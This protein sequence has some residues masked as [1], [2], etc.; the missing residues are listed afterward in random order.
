[1]TPPR[2]AGARG[3]GA[4]PRWKDRYFR[5]ASLRASLTRFAGLRV[6]VGT[7]R[8]GAG[9][10]QGGRR[11]YVVVGYG[12]VSAQV[13]VQ[14]PGFVLPPHTDGPDH[15]HAVSIVL[16]KPD[17]GELRFFGPHQ[18]LARGRVAAFD[19]GQVDHYVTKIEGR[20]SRVVLL[21]QRCSPDAVTVGP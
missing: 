2:R 7:A 9:S 8:F 13:Q 16:R 20:R 21:L 5:F 11:F 15:N 12:L 1:M 3:G 14:R 6:N 10:D 19:G 4:R 17:A 18:R